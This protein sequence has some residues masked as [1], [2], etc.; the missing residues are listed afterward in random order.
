M[1]YTPLIDEVRGHVRSGTALL[2]PH[3][4]VA[5]I[6]SRMALSLFANATEPSEALVG[7]GS[8]EVKQN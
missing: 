6:G 3:R 7:Q 4:L 5:C 2:K 8:L 1:D